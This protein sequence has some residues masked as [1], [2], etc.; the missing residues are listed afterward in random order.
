[1]AAQEY[2]QG[3]QQPP[4][5]TPMPFQ[6]NPPPQ[7]QSPYG[8]SPRTSNGSVNSQPRYQTPP[9]P[10]TPGPMPVPQK[11]TPPYPTS[12]YPPQQY[13]A[14]PGAVPPQA[15]SAPTQSYFPPQPQPNGYGYGPRPSDPYAYPPQAPLSLQRSISEPPDGRRPS[16]ASSQSSQPRHNHHRRDYDD[17]DEDS[18]YERS[19][20]RD[21]RDRRPRPKNKHSDTSTFLGAGGGAIVGDAIFPGLGTLGGLL[22]GGWGGREYSRRRSKSEMNAKPGQHHNGRK[23]SYGNGITVRSEWGLIER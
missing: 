12:N 20:S 1:M 11:Q 7:S 13:L 16:L 5:S 3:F 6:S 18:E 17:E 21:S 14:P 2:Y 9:Y 4:R 22:L 8:T 10:T 15:G 23:A 19:R